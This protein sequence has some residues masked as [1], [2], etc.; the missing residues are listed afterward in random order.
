MTINKFDIEREKN[1]KI[2]PWV[3]WVGCGQRGWCSAATACQEKGSRCSVIINDDTETMAREKNTP[4]SQQIKRERAAGL[5][6][7]VA[8]MAPQPKRLDGRVHGE[9]PDKQR[10]GE[11]TD[12]N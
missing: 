11:K 1:K 12:N 8:W 2:F 7:Y 5:K 10:Q 6:R 9:M 3:I 4:L